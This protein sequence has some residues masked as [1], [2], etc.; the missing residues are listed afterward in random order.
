MDQ[1]IETE[2]IDSPKLR[3]TLRALVAQAEARGLQASG[4]ILK[5]LGEHGDVGRRIATF[6][7]GR[8][9]RMIVVGAP[10]HG[11]YAELLGASTTAE[12]ARH[13]HS[14]LHI[15]HSPFADSS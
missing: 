6:A 8:H 5:V 10:T 9:A 2:D 11:Y 13:T 4:H 15:V 3:D 7:D 12:L 1:A 14:D